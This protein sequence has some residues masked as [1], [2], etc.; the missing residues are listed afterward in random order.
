MW[1]NA[2]KPAT[3][4]GHFENI[5]KEYDNHFGR[6]SS[7]DKV[8]KTEGNSLNSVTQQLLRYYIQNTEQRV[9]ILLLAMLKKCLLIV[10]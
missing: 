1:G 7:K 2:I 9:N 6:R 4:W 8:H 10:F 5:H 3:Q